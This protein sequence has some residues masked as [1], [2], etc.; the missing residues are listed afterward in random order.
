MIWIENT[1]LKAVD[2]TALA[3]DRNMLPDPVGYRGEMVGRVLRGVEIP[4]ALVIKTDIEVLGTVADRL[5]AYQIDEG[6][7]DRAC[8]EIDGV[9]AR[10]KGVVLRA[11]AENPG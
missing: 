10:A 9:V 8:P 5:P 4:V 2:Q 6:V 7:L 3:T 1:V 11:I